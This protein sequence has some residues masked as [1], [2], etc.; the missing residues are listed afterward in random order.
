MMRREGTIGTVVVTLC[1]PSLPLDLPSL[2]PPCNQALQPPPGP[3]KL[4]GEG[5][6]NRGY[7]GLGGVLREATCDI[8]AVVSSQGNERTLMA[9]GAAPPGAASVVLTDAL[10][11]V[12][13]QA[14][15][16][17]AEAQ[18]KVRP[19][20]A[21]FVGLK[22][23][24]ATTTTRRNNG[25]AASQGRMNKM[26][27]LPS[28][29]NTA[30]TAAA[31]AATAPPRPTRRAFKRLNEARAAAEQRRTE[32]PAAPPAAARA[33]TAGQLAQAHGAAGALT[34]SRSTRSA[35]AQGTTLVAP[36][37]PRAAPAAPAQAQ[38]HTP[39]RPLVGAP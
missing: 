2:I 12:P 15:I 17:A 24:A 6:V 32:R 36:L 9:L 13:I 14:K 26:Q 31:L 20:S 7:R 27:S 1:P 5:S 16:H 4:Q 39:L 34:A 30:T 3:C 35:G 18:V 25:R 33:S 22:H 38:A 8:A 28:L 21:R 19:P 29:T 11:C 23:A 37:P 10:T